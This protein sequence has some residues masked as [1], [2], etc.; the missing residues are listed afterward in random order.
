MSYTIERVVLTNF[1]PFESG[2]VDLSQPGLTTVEGEIHGMPG[3]TSNGSG[4]SML[5]DAPTWC[6]FDR[7]LRPG[8]EGDAVMRTVYERL[9]SGILRE[10]RKPNGKSVR[11]KGGTCVE[12]T[13]V[14][15]SPEVRVARYRGHPKHKN[16]VRLWLD[17]VD[18]TRG[19][20]ADTNAAIVQVLGMD[21]TA[22]TN[23]IAFAARDD[24]RSFFAAPDAQRKQVLDRILGLEVYARALALAR[25]RLALVQQESSRWAI[26]RLQA[27]QRLD[28]CVEALAAEVGSISVE[29]LQTALGSEQV[30]QRRLSKQCADASKAVGEA[31]HALSDAEGEAR[32]ERARHQ[33]EIAEIQKRQ[34]AR[35]AKIREALTHRAGFAA[36]IRD[37]KDALQKLSMMEDVDCPTCQQAVPHTH[38]ARVDAV[39]Q[40]EVKALEVQLA[41]ADAALAHLEDTA[42]ASATLPPVPTFPQLDVCRTVLQG[43]EADRRV[44]QEKFAAIERRV[45]S[46]QQQLAEV[47]GRHARLVAN[48]QKAT[49]RLAEVD[50][51]SQETERQLAQLKVCVSMF[52]NSGLKSFLIEATLPVINKAATRYARQLC[53][54]GAQIRLLATRQLK[55]SDAVREEMSVECSIPG[56]ATSYMA[57]SKG[58]KR[59]L[60]LS[61]L[62]A[63]RD[64]VATR[65]A[66]RINQCFADELFDGLDPAGCDAAIELLRQTAESCPVVLVT[67][68]PRL[69]AVGDRMVLVRHEN[70]V[71]DVVEG[72]AVPEEVLA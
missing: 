4:K 70:G 16:A 64:V 45:A 10:A 31:K 30:L 44:L 1:G 66:A 35:A 69:K 28:L 38:I 25:E 67:H 54:P 29:D 9:P 27:Q 37:K 14:G 36:Q 34:A 62:L 50:V 47:E 20:N 26:E 33:T 65:A 42:A 60:D 19:R 15:E 23:T 71:A 48:K 32:E 11:A 51:E 72:A 13:L 56:A 2:C 59:R 21:F 58:Q 40:K 3:C 39:T 53:G 43:A 57:A 22:F 5:L 49:E 8:Y 68:D 7:C 61:L 46:L 52:G 18:V 17:G 24:V 41:K 63:L 55:S 6:L 12:V